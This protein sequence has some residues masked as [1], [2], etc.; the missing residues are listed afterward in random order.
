VTRG[1][2]YIATGDACNEECIK[3][4]NSVKHHNPELKIHIFSERTEVDPVFDEHHLIEAPSFSNLDKVRHLWMTPF[5]ETLFLDSDTFITAELDSLFDGLKYCD[6]LGALAHGFEK[7]SPYT[8]IPNSLWEINTGVLLFNNSDPVIRMLKAWPDAYERMK[9]GISAC[10]IEESRAKMDQPSFRQLLWTARDVRFG[11]LPPEYN[12]L[13]YFGSALWGKAIIVHGRA[14]IEEVARRLNERPG[15][16]IFLQGGGVL[17]EFYK[18]S[19]VDSLRQWLRLGLGMLAH[20]LS[21][22]FS[23]LKGPLRNR[24]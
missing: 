22:V 11:V 17:H 6:L 1:V 24:Q 9:A 13:R 16:R 18:H 7:Q 20:H 23:K 14:N 8:D 10:G 2:V 19:F 21:P 12:L 5:D 4:A 3:S 15:N